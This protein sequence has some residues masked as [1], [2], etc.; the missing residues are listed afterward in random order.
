M[1]ARV[2]ST[3]KLPIVFFLTDEAADKRNRDVSRHAA[4]ARFCTVSAA[5][6]TK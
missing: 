2:V 1:V 6:C 3:Q 4:E 5:I